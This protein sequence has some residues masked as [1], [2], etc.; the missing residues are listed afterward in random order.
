V[1]FEVYEHHDPFLFPKWAFA[2][3]ESPRILRQK[4]RRASIAEGES[5]CS[6]FSPGHCFELLDHPAPHLDATYVLTCVEHRGELH[7]TGEGA[8]KVY[9]NTF[10]CA[11]AAMP[12]PPP[13]PKRA[14]VQVMLTATV[15]GPAG[16]EIHVDEKGQIRVQFH[17]DREGRFDDK[18]S[19]WIRVMQP[20]AGAAWGTQFIPRVGREVTDRTRSREAKPRAAQRRASA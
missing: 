9:A 1:P 6:D 14:S 20:W 11:P 12:Y 2:F 16:E 8:W 5:G 19:C 13:R 3:D 18:S 4:R 10:E 17:W 7:P 15:V